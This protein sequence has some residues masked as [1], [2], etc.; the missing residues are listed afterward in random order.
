V[1]AAVALTSRSCRPATGSGTSS[2]SGRPPGTRIVNV[3]TE[4]LADG[5]LDDV[6]VLLRGWLST[7]AFDRF[8][9]QAPRLAWSTRLGRRRERVLT[10]PVYRAASSS[11]TPGACSR[12]PSPSTSS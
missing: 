11:R 12:G 2:G 3:S 10:P 5:S 9:A 7:D 6:E 8:I 4:G 1:P